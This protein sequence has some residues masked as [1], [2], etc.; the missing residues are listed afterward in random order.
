MGTDW[1]DHLTYEFR[2]DGTFSYVAK[3]SGTT[4][5]TEMLAAASISKVTVSS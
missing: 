3:K 5:G 4:T 1:V 2:P